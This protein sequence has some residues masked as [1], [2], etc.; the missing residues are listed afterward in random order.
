MAKKLSAT[1]ASRNFSEI[2]GRVHLRGESFLLTR[3]GRV[4][5]QLAPAEPQRVIR[6]GQLAAVLDGLPR[7]TVGDAERFDQDLEA[8]AGRLRAPGDPW[9]S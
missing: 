5:A 9:D 3:H 4:I 7:L 8:G 6:L 2:L 1:E